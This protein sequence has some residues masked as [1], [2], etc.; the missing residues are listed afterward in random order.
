MPARSRSAATPAPLLLGGFVALLTLVTLELVRASGPLIDTAFSESGALGASVTAGLTYAAPGLVAAVL[1]LGTSRAARPAPVALTAGGVLLAVLRLVVQGLRGDARFVLGLVGVAVA[2]AVLSLAVAVLGGRAGGGRAAAAAVA[3]GAGAS[4]GLQLALGTWDASWRRT[5]LGWS[6]AVLLAVGLVLLAVLVARDRASAPTAP[7]GRVWALG[8]ALALAAM[9]LANPAFAAAQS[10]LP[11]AVAGPLHGLGWLLAGALLVRSG[12]V[13]FLGRWRV[14]GSAAGLVAGVAV[15]LGLTG[16]SLVRSLLVEVALLGAQL[17]AAV[18][19][20]R[21][22]EPRGP[23]RD[24]AGVGRLG[25]AAAVAVVGLATIV[26]LL[27]YQLDYD[28]PL[29]FPNELVMVVVAALLGGAGLRVAGAGLSGTGRWDASG[30]GL[31]LLAAG[32]FLLLGTVLAVAGWAADRPRDEVLGDGGYTGRIVSWNLH[33]GVTPTGAVD[34]EA[35]AQTIEAAD[36]DVVLLQEVSRGWV[37][38]GGADMATWLSQRLD[39]PFVFGAAADGR[40]GNVI[41]ARGRLSDVG[42]R[43]LPYGSGP[44]QRSAVSA[45]TRVGQDTVT[46][47]S[48]HLQHRAAN[49]ATRLAQVETLLAGPTAAGSA[50]VVGGDLNVT[51]GSPEVLLLTG[52]GLVSAVDSAGDPAALTDPSTGPKRRID[53]VFG[54][55]VSFAAASVLVGVPLSDHLPLVVSVVS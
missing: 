26:P 9:M 28:A 45:V 6:V 55:G 29:G 5:P 17:A 42:V 41:L 10:G 24:R 49:G 44:Q 46:V 22:L 1:L 38:G 37:Q 13:P 12:R 25:V 11:L 2:L 7:V 54:R 3:T 47:T 16:T 19:L 51:P 39:R 34:L 15:A 33:Y 43:S 20:G 35:V 14:G 36:P 52:A 31:P 8:P 18:L 21:A 32:V 53:W 30:W 4:V 40:F 23:A 48:L 50:W 27:A